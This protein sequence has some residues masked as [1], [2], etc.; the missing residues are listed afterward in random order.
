MSLNIWGGQIHKPFLNF[1]KRYSSEIDVFCLQEVFYNLDNQKSRIIHKA[2]PKIFSDIQQAL[3][4]HNGYF[5]PMQSGEEGLALFI[6]SA[7]EVEKTGEIFVYRALNALENNDASL[8]GRNLQYA[9]IKV[10]DSVVTISHIHGLWQGGSKTDTPERL[11]QSKNIKTFLDNIKGEKLL[12]GDFNLLPTTESIAILE[13]NMVNLIKEYGVTS[14][15]SHLSDKHDKYADYVLVSP[16]IKV[17]D[18]Q[19][20]NEVVSDHLAL[21]VDFS[22]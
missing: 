11:E 15:R 17:N 6:N 16:G 21:I 22:L 4:N 18:F 9:Q 5:S 7:I 2:I 3:P 13:E 8:L 12:C 19:V 14:T 10:D 20:S 1:L